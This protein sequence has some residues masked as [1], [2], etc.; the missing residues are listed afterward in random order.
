MA[1]HS[2]PGLEHS[3]CWLA[4]VESLLSNVCEYMSYCFYWV[5]YWWKKILVLDTHRTEFYI[6]D[7]CS[8]PTR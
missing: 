5:L 7:S 8:D 1:S 3:R 4:T 2:I 6:V